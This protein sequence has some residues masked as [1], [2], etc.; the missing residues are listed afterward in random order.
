MITLLG[1]L[2]LIITRSP[3]MYETILWKCVYLGLQL[4]W[5]KINS[6]I[7][8]PYIVAEEVTPATLIYVVNIIELFLFN[9]I[10]FHLIDACFMLLRPWFLL[11]NLPSV[12]WSSYIAPGL[13][14]TAVYIKSFIHVCLV[15]L[16][17]SRLYPITALRFY[18]I[19]ALHLVG[20]RCAAALGI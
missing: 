12:L 10:T 14:E 13:Y 16:P 11:F 1:F 17:Q 20:L 7:S 3:F 15:I 8:M 18:P 2:D 6:Q 19:T 5:L 9:Q 4:P